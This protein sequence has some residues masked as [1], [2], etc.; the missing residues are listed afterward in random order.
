MVQRI[1]EVWG[2]DDCEGLFDG[3]VEFD[4]TYSGGKRRNKWNAERKKAE[5]RGPV[6]LGRLSGTSAALP[7]RPY[8]KW[9]N[10]NASQTGFRCGSRF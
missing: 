10:A 2:G 5:G 1:R 3:P 7:T 4:E 8:I 6:D 9:G